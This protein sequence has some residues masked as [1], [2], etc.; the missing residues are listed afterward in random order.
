MIG[1]EIEKLHKEGAPWSDF[2]ILYRASHLSRSLEQELLRRRIPYVIWGGVRFF[3]RREIKDCLAYLRLIAWNDNLSFSRI[4]N[5]PSRRFGRTSLQKIREY[6]AQERKPYF[7]VLKDHLEEW[8]TTRAYKPLKDF[9]A[10]IEGARG[11]MLGSTVSELLNKVLKESGLTQALREDPETERLENV[12]ELLNSIRH[13]ESRRDPDE[14]SVPGYLQDIALFTNADYRAD[15][16]SVRLMTIHQAKGLEFPTVFVSGL[17]EGIFPSHRSLRERRLAALEEERRLMYV[18]VTRAEHRLYLSESEGW[19]FQTSAD[20]YPSRFLTEIPERMLLRE[21][22]IDKLL[23]EGSKSLAR[24][25]DAEIGIR[26]AEPVASYAAPE[27]TPPF[28]VGDRV[29]H[30]YFGEG[31][32]VDVAPDGQKIRV[33]FGADATSERQLMARVLTPL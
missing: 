16:D 14:I 11:E 4:V 17:S 7:E 21:G 12:E 10:L 23:W 22:K 1:R 6:S 5:N 15:T 2:A 33:R 25:I 29:S 28:R 20:K 19:N 8:K 31:T 27:L 32:V 18:A 24:S 9:I 13:Y 3:E 26:P 30:K